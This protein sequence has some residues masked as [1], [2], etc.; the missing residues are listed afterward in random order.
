MNT[1]SSGRPTQL[2]SLWLRLMSHEPRLRPLWLRWGVAVAVTL[3]ALWLRIQMGSPSS[4]ARFATL[5][6]ATVISAFFGGVSAGLLSTVLGMILVNFFMIAPF[7][8]MAVKNPTEAFWLNATYLL[9]QLVILGAIWVMQQRHQRLREL[10]RQLGESQRKFQD[11]FEHAAAGITHV[12]L[13][14]QLLEVNQTFCQL[15]G[16][17]EEELRHMSFQDITLPQ[18][19]GPDLRLLEETLAGR[20]T[21]YS[22]EKRYRH[23]DGHIIWGQITVSLIRKADGTPHYFISVVQDI[24]HVKSTQEALRTS[25]SLM[26]QAQGVA[27]FVTWEVNLAHE[28]FRTLGDGN[29]ALGLPSTEF[30]SDHVLSLT[31]PDDH[32]QLK[33]EWIAAPKGDKG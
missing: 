26:S 16:Y 13:Q 4:G 11:T 29:E 6:L 18:D 5:T 33:E 20:R 1:S 23:K 22:L 8:Q 19:I 7:G 17:T 9:T 24:S 12:G 28:Q 27:K 21:H 14:G 10:T 3:L 31:H 25:E 30:S 2:P 32:A 15:V